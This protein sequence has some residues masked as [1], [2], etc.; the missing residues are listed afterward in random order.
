MNSKQLYNEIITPTLAELGLYREEAAK[1]VL[2]TAAHES[3]CG[4]YIKQVG[5]IAL[6]IYQCE[7]LTHADIARFIKTRH[8]LYINFIQATSIP[9]SLFG[10]DDLLVSNLRYATAICRIHYYRIP[11]PIPTDLEGMAKY[12][13]KYYNTSLGKGKVDD[14]IKHAKSCKIK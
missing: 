7:P 10:N 14:F 12:W 1:L 4:K 5:G 9:A 6:G 8:N 2:Y 13:K 3:L 11:H